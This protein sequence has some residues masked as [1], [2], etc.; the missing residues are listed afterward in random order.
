MNRPSTR[1][2]L[3]IALAAPRPIPTDREQLEIERLVSSDCLRANDFEAFLEE[4][5]FAA[6][7]E[8]GAGL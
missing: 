1:E 2:Q 5:R 8:K 3:E 6:F 4:I 7:E